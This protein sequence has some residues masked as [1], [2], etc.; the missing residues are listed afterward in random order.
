MRVILVMSSSL[1]YFAFCPSAYFDNVSM[2][3]KFLILGCEVYGLSGYRFLLQSEDMIRVAL[4]GDITLYYL[5]F[6]GLAIF[7]ISSASPLEINN[8]PWL[9]NRMTSIMISLCF[10]RASS[11]QEF[12][13]VSQHKN[14]NK[15]KEALRK[16]LKKSVFQLALK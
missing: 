4:D 11:L 5:S 3:R 7:Y 9:H 6:K 2:V 8:P 14:K 15:P 10:L 13:D 1:F 16:L 12:V